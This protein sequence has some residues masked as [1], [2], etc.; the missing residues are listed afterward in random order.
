[1]PGNVAAQPPLAA[2]PPIRPPSPQDHGRQGCADGGQ[3]GGGPR[4]WGG[5][6]CGAAHRGG[7]EDAGPG[8][9]R[10]R[11]DGP[12]GHPR[13]DTHTHARTRA[14]KRAHASAHTRAGTRLAHAR[15]STRARSDCTCPTLCVAPA[16]ARL[17]AS[18]PTGL[19]A[20]APRRVPGAPPGMMTGIMT[21]TRAVIAVV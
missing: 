18:A 16:P 11:P 6:V 14:Y 8:C 17:A 15:P 5:A 9:R 7:E 21:T 20:A 2:D 4:A 1:M 10:T 3:H 12:D 19:P 13:T